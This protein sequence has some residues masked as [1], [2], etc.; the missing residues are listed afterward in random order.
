MLKPCIV[1]LTMRKEERTSLWNISTSRNKRNN[2]IVSVTKIQPG[3][4]KPRCCNTNTQTPGKDWWS[5]IQF[6]FWPLMWCINK[7]RL[8]PSPSVC[9]TLSLT[10]FL[11]CTLW[12]YESN[13]NILY[14]SH[15]YRIIYNRLIVNRLTI[16]GQPTILI[17]AFLHVCDFSLSLC[18]RSVRLCVHI[19]TPSE[20]CRNGSHQRRWLGWTLCDSIRSIPEWTCT[21]SSSVAVFQICTTWHALVLWECF[22]W[23]DANV[24]IS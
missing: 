20:D 3:N 6:V 7:C 22:E 16:Q 1:K 23:G 13:N 24:R 15:L 19:C 12:S 10:P 5:L 8:S 4:M 2:W 21:G 18:T 11:S 14:G 9:L 17:I